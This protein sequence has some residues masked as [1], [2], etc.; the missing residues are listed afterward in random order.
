[1]TNP[2]FPLLETFIIK[3][4]MEIRGINKGNGRHGDATNNRSRTVGRLKI[5]VTTLDGRK[6]DTNFPHQKKLGVFPFERAKG[7]CSYCI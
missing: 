1:M 3:T 6:K 2:F 7:N 4:Y 5:I